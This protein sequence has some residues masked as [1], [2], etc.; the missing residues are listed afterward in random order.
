MVE[1]P[2]E[3]ETLLIAAVGLTAVQAAGFLAATEAA[4]TLAAIT[5]AAEIE[6]RT[7]GRKAANPLT[8]NRGTSGQHRFREA[9]VDNRRRSWQDDSRSAWRSSIGATNEK[10]RLRKQPGFSS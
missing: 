1:A 7:T 3:A 10:P 5:M 6:D 2:I 9:A 8:K 4:I